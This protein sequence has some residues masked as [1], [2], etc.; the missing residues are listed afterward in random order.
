MHRSRRWRYAPW[1]VALL[2][3]PSVAQVVAPLEINDPEL[4]F[5]QSE[6]MDAL[7]ALGTEISNNFV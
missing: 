3:V 6:Y 5:Q 1:Q 7:R 2:R 4:R